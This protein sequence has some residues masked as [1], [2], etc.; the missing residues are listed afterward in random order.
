MVEDAEGG[1]R[2]GSRRQSSDHV[3]LAAPEHDHVVADVGEDVGEVG[4]DR[5]LPV[6]Q[7]ADIDATAFGDHQLQ[8]QLAAQVAQVLD[9]GRQPPAKLGPTGAGRGE[10]RAVAAGDARLLADSADRARDRRVGRASG[11]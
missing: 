11:R 6:Q 4:D 5:A 9:R 2:R 1:R 10:D 3:V 7:V 8:Q